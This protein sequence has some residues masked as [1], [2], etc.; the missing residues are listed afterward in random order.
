[1][2]YEI[3]CDRFQQKRIR[4][5][6]GLSVVLGTRTGDNS[7]GKSTFLLIVDFV[8][9][10]STYAKTEDIIKNVG[11]HD[12][13]FSFIFDGETFRFCRNSIE[14]HTVWKCNDDYERTEEIKLS[15]YC[16]WLDSKY[17]MLEGISLPRT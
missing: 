4:F 12:I 8:F 7:I 6:S 2:L 5:N 17:A 10:G 9:G 16:E 3:R 1:M 11:S 13:Y 15:D 14:A